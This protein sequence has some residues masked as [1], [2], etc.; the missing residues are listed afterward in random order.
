MTV[1][2][3]SMMQI[4]IVQEIGQTLAGMQQVQQQPP[5]T[6]TSASSA[7]SDATCAQR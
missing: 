7:S 5:P 2:Q 6:P 4:Q 3:M 1:E